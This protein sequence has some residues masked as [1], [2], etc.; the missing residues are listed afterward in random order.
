[1]YTEK[2]INGYIVHHYDEVNS[3]STVCAQ[4]MYQYSTDKIVIVTDLQTMGR[5]R[6][7]SVWQSAVGNLMT[8]VVLPLKQKKIVWSDISF[9]TALAISD[10]IR[11]LTNDSN[12]QVKWS[13]DVLINGDKIAGVLLEAYEN[14]LCIGIGINVMSAPVVSKYGTASLLGLGVSI[15][16]MQVLKMLLE[17]LDVWMRVWE[18]QGFKAILS[19][20]KS[21]L[22]G[23]GQKIC[24]RTTQESYKG[25]FKG[26]DESGCAV[27]EL[28][29][30]SLKN[31]TAGEM[32]FE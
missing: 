3:T 6:L 7:G 17:R 30:K 2:H 26:V 16:K 22:W 10:C 11:E 31:F 8:T 5:G 15:N 24:I 21:R 20:Y 9:I 1:M 18:E 29:D 23:V 12:T 19:V 4:D 28:A 13:N 14:T 25:I 27:L 32:S